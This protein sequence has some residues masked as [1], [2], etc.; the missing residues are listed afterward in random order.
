GFFEELLFR[1]P[2]QTALLRKASPAFAIVIT[3]FVFGAAHLDLHGLLLRTILG[4]VLG[5]VVWRTGSIFPAMLLHALYDSTSLGLAAWHLH[6]L[7]PEGTPALF[8]TGV[9]IRVGVGLTLAATGFWMLW[10]IRPAAAP[11]PSPGTP[12][13]GWGEGLRQTP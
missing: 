10:Q 9:A 7:G 2:I 11:A 8:D 13:E 3:A 12:G 4:I 6:R 5:Y 1:G